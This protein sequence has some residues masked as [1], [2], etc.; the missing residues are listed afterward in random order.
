MKKLFL[1]ILVLFCTDQNKNVEA[2]WVGA[3]SDLSLTIENQLI[4][5]SQQKKDDALQLSESGGKNFYGIDQKNLETTDYKNLKS[6]LV[7]KMGL[8]T[9][10]MVQIVGSSNPFSVEGTKI[11]RDFLRPFFEGDHM[12]E[13]GFTGHIN[14]D[15]SK[16]DINSFLNEYIECNPS[17]AYRVLANVLGH[18]VAAMNNWGCKVSDLV[19]HFVLVFNEHGMGEGFTKFGDDV[20]AS[21]FIMSPEDNDLLVVVE[22]GAQS[23]RQAVNVLEK[24]VKVIALGNVREEQERI[25]FS[26]SEFLNRV[27]EELTLNPDLTPESVREILQDY[28]S[29]HFAWDVRR[30][31]A[32]TKAALFYSTVDDFVNKGIYKKLIDL[33]DVKMVG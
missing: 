21:D 4:N 20:I 33:L 32:G 19:S 26:A 5:F 28:L 11:A 17:Q 22:G 8:K 16:L 29:N 18:S 1:I 13:Y 14:E 30:P 27:K 24:N 31:D 10:R 2:S 15:M 12:L 3:N 23:F 25:I 6:Q 9:R 7:E